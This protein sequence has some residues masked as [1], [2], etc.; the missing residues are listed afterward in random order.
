[1]GESWGSALGVFLVDMYP[2]SYHALIGTGQMVDFAETERI[3]YAEALEI[4]QSKNDAT[5]MKRLKANGEP[6]Y[7]GKDVTWKSAVYLNYLSAIWREIPKSTIPD[8]IPSVT[9][10]PRNR[11]CLIRSTIY[12]AL[13]THII[14]YTNSFCNGD[15]IMFFGK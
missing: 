12:V 3:D 15:I 4:A 13:S 14:M 10:L 7:Y 2:D 5:L 11:G 9:S 8:T 1:M 6:P